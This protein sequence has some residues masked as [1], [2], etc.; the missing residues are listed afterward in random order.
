MLSWMCERTRLVKIK[1]DYI[2]QKVQVARVENK[3]RDSLEMVWLCVKL[4]VNE[5]VERER[6]RPKITWKKVVLKGLQFFGSM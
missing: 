1:N 3:M 2:R 4:M 5:G 6:G